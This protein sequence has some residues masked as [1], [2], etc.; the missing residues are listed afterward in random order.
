MLF[1]TTLTVPTSL[2]GHPCLECLLS[3]LVLLGLN[4]R[5]AWLWK[6]QS[7]HKA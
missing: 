1:S 6:P 3:S 7:I 4:S 2:Q 5:L